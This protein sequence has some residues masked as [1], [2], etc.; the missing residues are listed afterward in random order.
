M[1]IPVIDYTFYR[2]YRTFQSGKDSDPAYSTLSVLILMFGGLFTYLS[3]QFNLYQ[4][5]PDKAG[6]FIIYGVVTGLLWLTFFNK[7]RYLKISARFENENKRNVQLGYFY[8]VILALITI[9]AYSGIFI[10]K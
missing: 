1:R 8:L 2:I 9:G 4:Y 3:E 6:L 5:L 7:K 10:I